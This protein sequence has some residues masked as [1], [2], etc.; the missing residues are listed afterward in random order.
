MSGGGTRTRDASSRRLHPALRGAEPR[1]RRGRGR[2]GA[3][4]GG[5]RG[6]AMGD[7]FGGAES[8]TQ[9][10]RGPR[11]APLSPGLG[12]TGG[13]GWA[14]PQPGEKRSAEPPS[15]IPTGRARGSPR[16]AS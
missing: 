3:L 12:H 5:G 4:R 7:A 1:R 13:E 14:R 16:G 2:A 8:G 15:L 6:A 9:V 10:K 11:P